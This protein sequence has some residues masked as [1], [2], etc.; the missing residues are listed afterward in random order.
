MSQEEHPK[1]LLSTLASIDFVADEA[2]FFQDLEVLGDRGLGQGELIDELATHARLAP[3]EE[4]DDRDPG[5]VTE[6]LRELGKQL[7]AA[8][9]RARTLA[10]GIAG[11]EAFGLHACYGTGLPTPAIPSKCTPSK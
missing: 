4:L 10:L 1:P 9:L 3:Q 11:T 6:G 5:G 8:S 2:S 7:L